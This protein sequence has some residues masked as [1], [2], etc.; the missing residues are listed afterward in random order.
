[1]ARRGP[2]SC[3]WRGWAPGRACS[4]RRRR[5]R[6]ALVAAVVRLAPEV[7]D[8]AWPRNEID[9]FLPAK[10]GNS[11][12]SRP[13]PHRQRLIRRAGFDPGGCPFARGRRRSW[14]TS[15]PTP[16]KSSSIACL[17][18]P[19]TASRWARHWLDIVRYADTNG[20]ERDAEKPGSAL[21]RLGDQV[22]NAD[23]GNLYDRFILEQLAGDEIEGATDDTRVATGFRDRHVRRRAQ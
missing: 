2:F 21:P 1:M 10:L 19:T 14:P 8:A 3:G 22:L 7:K 11:A 15:R 18:A 16:T 12:A 4:V 5:G 17:P 9:R 13:C 20:Y 23:L 6:R